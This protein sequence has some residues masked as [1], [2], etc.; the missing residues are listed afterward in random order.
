M[1][2]FRSNTT[3]S[4]EACQSLARCD[5]S[6]V[7]PAC[8]IVTGNQVENTKYQTLQTTSTPASHFLAGACLQPLSL[9][10]DSFPS[11]A[12]QNSNKAQEKLH[13]R[14]MLKRAKD[15][16]DFTVNT[17]AKDLAESCEQMREATSEQNQNHLEQQEWICL[18]L[19]RQLQHHEALV[20]RE[21]Q[22]AEDLYKKVSEALSEMREVMNCRCRGIASQ[23]KS[24][25]EEQ[26]KKVHP[27]CSTDGATSASVRV[28]QLSEKEVA[29]SWEEVAM[30]RLKTEVN[31]FYEGIKHLYPP[32]YI[33]RLSPSST[34]TTS[35]E[36]SSPFAAGRL[37]R[38]HHQRNHKTAHTQ[39]FKVFVKVTDCRVIQ[40]P[41]E[42]TVL[43]PQ[44]TKKFQ[45]PKRIKRKYC[46]QQCQGP[47][48][49]SSLLPSLRSELPER[50]VHLA[51]H[52]GPGWSCSSILGDGKETSS[53]SSCS[54]EFPT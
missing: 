23:V 42:F 52:Y 22:L 33:Y 1:E 28:T 6:T 46:P 54:Q 49:R 7:M 36:G 30:P 43:S 40:E 12:N 37:K 11:D 15:L 48:Y 3:S 24:S 5:R 44:R 41:M 25:C 2:L 51:P 20:V 31:P 13:N 18:H 35:S 16:F 4:G 26:F 10:N 34:P 29:M 50:E 45:H 8:D 9:W 27:N 21:R 47:R 32:D 53:N 38:R 19:T 17:V 14:K 39:D